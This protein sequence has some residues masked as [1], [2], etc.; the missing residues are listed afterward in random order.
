MSAWECDIDGCGERFDSVEDAIVHQTSEHE[1]QECKVCGA[2]VPDGYFAIRHAFDEHS[3]AEYV[4]A[5]DAN[6][7]DVR[8]RERIR[9]EIEETADLKGVVSRLDLTGGELP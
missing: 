5:Y 3:R 7:S 1:R 2:V 6:S 4:R 9:D 8:T